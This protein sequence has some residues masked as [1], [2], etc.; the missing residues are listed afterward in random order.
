MCQEIIKDIRE[1]QD[2]SYEQL[3]KL[4][5]D[6]TTEDINFLYE[7]AR[8]A[9][10]EVYGRRVEFTF[11]LNLLYLFLHYRFWAITT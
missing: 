10:D 6:A 3:Q 5:N 1:K 9:A 7:Q 4:L 8:E 2:I 11:S